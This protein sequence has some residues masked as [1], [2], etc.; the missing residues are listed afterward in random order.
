MKT[1]R[2][3]KINNKINKK[4]L[5]ILMGACM[6]LG[7]TAVAAAADPDPVV[8]EFPKAGIDI[9]V[10]ESWT[11]SGF[12]LYYDQSEITPD[13]IMASG[14]MYSATEEELI[15]AG[16]EYTEQE[17][18]SDYL[19]DKIYDLFII[20]SVRDDFGYDG[21]VSYMSEEM[22]MGAPEEFP[23]E[24]KEIGK[25]DGWTFYD[26]SGEEVIRRPDAGEEV[27]ETVD[28]ILGDIPEIYENIR[29]YEPVEDP[30][31]EEGTQISFKTVD[32]EGNEVDSKELFAQ[33]DFTLVNLWMSWCVYCVEEMPELEKMNGEFAED[34]CAV[35]GI[36]LD[37][38]Q[39]AELQTGKDIVKETGVT[40]PML[41]ANDEIRSQLIAPAYPTTIFVDSEGV[42]VGE[43]I[44]GMQPDAYR[45]RIKEL[46]EGKKKENEESAPAEDT[47][48]SAEAES[49]GYAVLVQDENGDPVPD[50]MVQFCSDTECMME[51]TDGDGTAAF[52]VE[53]GTYT[54]HILKVSEGFEEDSEEYEAPAEPGTVEI[55]LKKK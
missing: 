25:S 30:K 7:T 41:I 39:E 45:E 36:M 22:D 33:H 3:K 14:V 31:T 9:T 19:Q 52:D 47:A 12:Y 37:G 10:P 20:M 8:W 6:V 2:I 54:V 21:M 43:P 15:A 11:D 46:A 16:E 17:D 32:F 35:I 55:T 34:N 1:K 48:S 23:F 50:V 42:T 40:Y 38:D 53:A 49:Q 27:K 18:F 51:T 29:F 26:I 5:S 44:V 13:F 28:K 24:I 4:I